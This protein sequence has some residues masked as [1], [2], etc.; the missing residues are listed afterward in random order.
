LGEELVF[1]LIEFLAERAELL[2]P[3]GDLTPKIVVVLF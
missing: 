1:L 2:L 3:F